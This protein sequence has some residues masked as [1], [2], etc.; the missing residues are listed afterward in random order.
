MKR[1]L[2]IGAGLALA[3]TAV[4]ALATKG[5]LAHGDGLK[6]KGMG[7]WPPT[8]TVSYKLA[9]R[10]S[11]GAALLLGYQRFKASGLQAIYNAPGFPAFTGDPGRV[12]KH[13]H[14]SVKGQGL[15]LGWP[16]QVAPGLSA[17]AAYSSRINRS[18]FDK[19]RGLFAGQGHFDTLPTGAAAW[20]GR[21]QPPG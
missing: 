1:Q 14:D 15:G 10:H 11:A 4:P 16:G 5:S 20:P 7:G 3:G 17:G 9:E 8:P 21:L 13:G 19:Y 12:T 2:G 18:R 6:V